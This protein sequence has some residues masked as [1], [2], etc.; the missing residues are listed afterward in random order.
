MTNIPVTVRS[1][2][3]DVETV[4]RASALFDLI[5][6]EAAQG[7]EDRQVTKA[8]T[9]AVDDAGLFNLMVPQRLG[10]PGASAR[11]MI[12]VLVE[13]GRADGS[14]GWSAALVNA[15]TWFAVTYSEQAQREI[16]GV[17][18]KAKACGIFFPGMTRRH[19]L[20]TGEKVEGGYL[21]TGEYPYASGN[22]VADWATLGMLI[23]GP[24]GTPAM[25]LGLVEAGDWT[26]KDTWFTLGMRGTGSNTLVV[27]DAY[28]PDHRIQTFDA[29]ARGDYATPYART[30]PSSRASFLPVGTVILAAPG[31]GLAKAALDYSLEKLPARSVGYTVYTEAR[32]SPTHHL[33]VAQAASNIDAAHLLLARAADDIDAFA[34][35]GAYPDERARGRIRMDTGHAVTLCK[36]A[37]D[38]LM[39]ANGAGAFTQDGLLG[40]IWRD[41]NAAGRHAFAT[42][43][44]GREV[45][46]RLLLG[47]DDPLTIAV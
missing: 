23:D 29:L 4:Q 25:A 37:I 21:L 3:P 11:T 2:G 38:V 18:P 32:N 1:P 15:C 13:L 5:R 47:A 35:A 8:V 33:A 12:E 44:I 31:I 7:Q 17:G 36:E 42:P 39:T 20:G 34:A 26:V 46:G 10:G 16:W 30:E 24:D 9:D 19:Q 6:S 41:A 27:K 43:E 22:A 28:V 45:Y 14:T 40:R